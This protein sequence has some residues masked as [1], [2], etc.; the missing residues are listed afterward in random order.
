MKE[1]HDGAKVLLSIPTKIKGGKRFKL[2]QAEIDGKELK[3]ATLAENGVLESVYHKRNKE[4]GSLQEQ[5]EFF[6]DNGYAALVA[7]DNNIKAKY[8]KPTKKK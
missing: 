5:W 7:R 3:D 1:L 4:R 2:T 8:P 6:I